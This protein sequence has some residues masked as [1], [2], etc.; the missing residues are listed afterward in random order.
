MQFRFQVTAQHDVGTAPGHIGGD[1]NHARTT[2]LGDNLRLLLMVFGV[3]HLVLDFGLAKTL[4]HRL[5]GFHGSSAHQH[6]RALGHTLLDIGQDS[7]EFFFHAEV[8]QV[9]QVLALLR[10]IGGNDQ[11]FQAVDLAELKCFG[12]GRTG[13]TGKLVIQAK[14]VLEGGR[15][16]S[17]AF[18]LD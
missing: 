13:H 12:V 1:G 9:V 8:D 15:C 7:V 3:Q 2:G 16:Q 5:R 6:R 18:A 4:G 10:H 11:D 14:V 17:L